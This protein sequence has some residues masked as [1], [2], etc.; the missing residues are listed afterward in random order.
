VVGLLI[1]YWLGGP[2]R[3]PPLATPP[4]TQPGATSTDLDNV[5]ITRL[6]ALFSLAK[7]RGRGVILSDILLIGSCVNINTKDR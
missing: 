3:V 2:F 7:L 6:R 1:G 4:T 5:T